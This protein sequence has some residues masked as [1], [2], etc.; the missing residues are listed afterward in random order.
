MGRALWQLPG[1]AKPDGP[2]ATVHVDDSVLP[3]LND[4]LVDLAPFPATL[5]LDLA[6]VTRLDEHTVVELLFALRDLRS[7]TIDVDVVGVRPTVVRRLERYGL[8]GVILVR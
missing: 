1:S 7:A 6:D 2:P 5:V 4:Y 8:V 3:R